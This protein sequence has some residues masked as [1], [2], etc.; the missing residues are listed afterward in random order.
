MVSNG[1]ETHTWP[2]T[3]PTAAVAATFA[4][5]WTICVTGACTLVDPFPSTGAEGAFAPAAN[6]VI[7]P[8]IH[9]YTTI[10]IPAGVTV[11]TNGSGVLDLRATGNITIA[12]TINV[13]GGLGGTGVRPTGG[14]GGGT[15][16]SQ[17]TAATG[18][19]GGAGA[20]GVAPAGSPSSGCGA[21]GAGGANGGGSGTASA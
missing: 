20:G 2:W 19:P 9:N 1:C 8:G 11:T 21:N 5:A 17:S 14:G 6:T 15:T 18:I 16:G 3:A 10:N 4:R 7:T 13:S 12:G